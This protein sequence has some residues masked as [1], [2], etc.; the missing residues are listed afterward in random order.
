MGSEFSRYTH[1]FRERCRQIVQNGAW[2]RS[3]TN[4]SLYPPAFTTCV[5]T[6][7]LSGTDKASLS[8]TGSRAG[9]RTS[10]HKRGKK[11]RTNA[12]SVL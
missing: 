4:G 11:S 8:E 12:F 10:D 2:S 7:I 5:R 9:R 3:L 1:E 6:L